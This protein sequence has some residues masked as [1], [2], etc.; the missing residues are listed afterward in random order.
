MATLKESV[1]KLGRVLGNI[2]EASLKKEYPALAEALGLNPLLA[3]SGKR[4]EIIVA[5]QESIN[6][7]P[8]ASDGVKSADYIARFFEKRGI[9][10]K[11]VI[12]LRESVMVSAQ[13]AVRHEKISDAERNALIESLSARKGDVKLT[14][15][16]AKLLRENKIGA[17]KW[18][19]P[20]SRVD[21]INANLRRYSKALWERVIRDQKHIWEGCV[22]LA[23]H[24]PGDADPEF[25]HSAVVWSNMRMDE[26]NKLVWADAVFVGE[27]GRLAEEI[28]EAGGKVGF[29]TAGLGDLERVTENVGG[30]FREFYEVIP[31]EF[32][33]ERIA[34]V[35]PNPS[36]D[37]FGI[38]D[39]RV[40]ETAS[41]SGRDHAVA[42]K[43]EPAE[44]R[45]V[46]SM[47]QVE[48]VEGEPADIPEFS[49]TDPLP[50]PT[51]DVREEGDTSL[52]ESEGA[53]AAG[54]TSGEFQAA[55]PENVSTVTQP[56]KRD[57]KDEGDRDMSTQM[58][59]YEQRRVRED[60]AK[61]LERADSLS[62][63]KDQLREYREIAQYVKDTGMQDLQ[64]S[65]QKRIETANT[66]LASILERGTEFTEIFG[67]D[68]SAKDVQ[69]A[70]GDLN[71]VKEN[72][73]ETS[74]DWKLVSTKMAKQLKKF[75]EAVDV[76][77]DRP[78]HA[79]HTAL[80]KRSKRVEETL[81]RQMQ[82]SRAEASAKLNALEKDLTKAHNAMRNYIKDSKEREKQD[83]KRILELTKANKQL[84]ESMKTL[85]ERAENAVTEYM[86]DDV[87]YLVES[88]RGATKQ[89]TDYRRANRSLTEAAST[90]SSKTAKN[91][92]REYYDSLLRKYGSSILPHSRS[93]LEAR[94][95]REAVNTFMNIMDNATGFD[96]EHILDM[97]N[98]ILNELM[99]G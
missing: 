75:V 61:F 81:R 8:D 65:V 69:K 28:L 19:F 67:T 27:K 89:S 32:L 76:L 9:K 46:N 10:E 94:S 39:M 20:I 48:P 98:P 40:A 60:I 88:G 35:V 25:K 38:L 84:K 45:L 2:T 21:Y 97:D 63:P 72:L 33:I 86:R 77:K 12:K 13:Q 93:I 73:S 16:T 99:Q 30:Q 51:E 42:Q 91:E 53:D 54:Q 11:Q 95:Y 87:K 17:S 14:E 57:K 18:S 71:S 37:V 6:K 78:T 90:T 58:T 47:S 1:D 52:R 92:V 24:P 68:L 49:E 62:N 74:Y 22:G 79:A 55:A 56:G 85:K 50:L 80:K 43:L 23:D 4:K 3:E 26:T 96:P 44:G 7:I 64:A 41:E 34:D 36:Q 70:I 5:I 29:S 82:A 83:Q 59:A 66:A 15:A 31:S